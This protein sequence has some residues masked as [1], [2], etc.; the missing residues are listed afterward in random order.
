[1]TI[2]ALDKEMLAREKADPDS[3]F[4]GFTAEQKA[5]VKADLLRSKAM[6]D[7]VN[8]RLQVVSH[9]S[10]SGGLVVT[11]RTVNL[12]DT[13]LKILNVFRINSFTDDDFPIPPALLPQIRQRFPVLAGVP[14]PTGS[15]AD[16]INATVLVQNFRRLRTSMDQQFKKVFYTQGTF[17]GRPIGFFA[18]FVNATNPADPT[19][20]ITRAYFNTLI[21]PAQDDRAVTLAH[22]RAAY[23]FPGEWTSGD[24]GQSVLRG[25]FGGSECEDGGP[26]V[27]ERILL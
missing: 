7:V 26:G 22:E 3:D 1:M 13:K 15:P 4:M 23:N 10:P 2:A 14:G 21:M 6:L 11:P 5:M 24:G 25:A 27:G 9:S 8:R 12:Y 18:A 19:V 20:R 17:K 16:A